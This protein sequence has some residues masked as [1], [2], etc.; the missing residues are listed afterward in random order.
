MI[1]KTTPS[2]LIHRKSYKFK[3]YF[4]CIVN[5]IPKKYISYKL[6]VKY[7]IETRINQTDNKRYCIV[8]LGWYGMVYGIAWYGIAS[9]STIE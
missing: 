4:N 1:R 8:L 5:F 3:K 2:K 7:L 6:T 9:R